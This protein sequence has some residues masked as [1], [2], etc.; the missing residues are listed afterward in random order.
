MTN[1][2]HRQTRRGPDTL[3]RFT[4][5]RLLTA[6]EIMSKVI[7]VTEE[8]DE[9]NAR[10][11]VERMPI[12]GLPAHLIQCATCLFVHLKEALERAGF[13][14]SDCGDNVCVKCGCTDSVACEEGCSWRKPGE[15]SAH[16]GE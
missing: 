12:S 14:C 6:G 1:A 2:L 8:V 7:V 11:I 3:P 5:N 10:S 4:I 16:G 9:N 15:C 13:V